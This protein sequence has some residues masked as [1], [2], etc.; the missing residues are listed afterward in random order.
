MSR[1]VLLKS[2]KTINDLADLLGV[3]HSGLSFVLYKKPAASKYQSFTIPKKA[4]GVRTIYAPTPDLKLLQRRLADLLQE[5]MEE[6]ETNYRAASKD[7]TPE[8]ISHGFHPGRSI[9]TNA[10]Q[11]RRRR[12][13]FNVDLEDFF[14]TCNFGRVRGLLL[15]NK[16]FLLHE[17]VATSI[18]HLACHGGALPQGAPSSPVLSNL[19]GRVLDFRL[20]KLANAV[21]CSYS[22]Y[23][24]D[25]TFST[26]ERQFPPQLAVEVP[27]RSGQW[28]PGLEL[29]NEIESSGFALNPKKTRMHLP[30]S[31]QMVTGLVVNS[32][33]NVRSDYRHLVRAMVYRLLTKGDFEIATSTGLV[34]GKLEQLQ[35]MLSF[36]E[37]IDE[38]SRKSFKERGVPSPRKRDE[39]FQDFVFF[40][41]IYCASRPTLIC[42]G[43]TDNV[44]LTHAI[45][46]LAQSFPELGKITPTGEVEIKVRRFKYAGT[47][48][49]KMLGLFGGT[50]DLAK[51]IMHYRK[52]IKKFKA[53]G[54]L[55][56]VIILID[57]DSGAKSVKS[58]VQQITGTTVM[59]S[60]DFI[61][62]FGNLYVITTPIA[63][64]QK[65]STIEDF[66]DA[67]TKAKIL[68]GKKFDPTSDAD[69]AT[70]YGKSAFAY[71]IVEAAPTKI[72]F[73]GFYPLLNQVRK[74]VA[75]FSVLASTSGIRR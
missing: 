8:K 4:G 49:G 36:I 68:N 5:C 69:T 65:E 45:R 34:K 21:G 73:S 27:P 22:R 18:A 14:G 35:G 3:T 71:R 52:A 12:Y 55:H 11:H 59:G 51:F 46:A 33:I 1:L 60:E 64:G 42:E 66:F 70:T 28:V 39:V 25:L 32:R 24:D 40:R 72:D 50:G 15:K 7:Q 38:Y 10:S 6:L 13:V 61:Y 17:R 74:V 67:A 62:L 30:E 63:K 20:V 54:M 19:I 44:Y 75:D 29:L 47:L 31:R 2:A 41:H 53:N 9:I 37:S 48:T 16:H 58:V 56:P 43:K 26:N 23:A 57:N